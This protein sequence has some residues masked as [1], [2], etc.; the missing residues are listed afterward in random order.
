MFQVFDSCSRRPDETI[1][2]FV[3]EL[4]KIVQ[5][6]NCDILQQMLRDRLVRGVNDD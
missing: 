5:D 1:T 4:C 3:A 2:D 6:C